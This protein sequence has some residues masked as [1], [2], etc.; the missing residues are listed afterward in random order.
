MFVRPHN[1]RQWLCRML[2]ILPACTTKRADISM[3]KIHAGGDFLTPAY[4][5]KDFRNDVHSFTDR[6]QLGKIALEEAVGDLSQLVA[7]I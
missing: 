6:I 2:Q 3:P 7:Q 1:R 5:V 4:M